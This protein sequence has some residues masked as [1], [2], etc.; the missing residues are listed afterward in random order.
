MLQLVAPVALVLTLQRDKPM[1]PCAWP[2]PLENTLVSK[3]L[4]VLDASQENSRCQG[5]V[6]AVHV[7]R[8]T[9]LKPTRLPV[10]SVPRGSTL[11]PR[12]PRV[13][14][15]HQE[16]SRWTGLPIAL[17]VTQDIIPRPM[18]PHVPPVQAENTPKLTPPR[19]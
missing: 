6:C 3:R 17:R 16:H 19:V 10:L 13:S 8:E 7:G 9:T 18:H 12:R 15:V 4:S 2:A 1:A 5:Q 11:G 14:L